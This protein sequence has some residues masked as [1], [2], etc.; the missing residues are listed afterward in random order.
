MS[1]CPKMWKSSILS[2]SRNKSISNLGGKFTLVLS[3]S[4]VTVLIEN[5]IILLCT[6][7]W[8]LNFAKSLWNLKF[9]VRVSSGAQTKFK[10]HSQDSIANN[11]SLVKIKYAYTLRYGIVATPGT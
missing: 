1:I 2:S 10:F 5:T 11:L 6:Y 9:V 3:P 4:I 8:G 7:F